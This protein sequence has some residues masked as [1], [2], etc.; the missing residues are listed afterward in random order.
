M[1]TGA[2]A[3][4]PA[5]A[6][7]AAGDKDHYKSAYRPGPVATLAATAVRA[8]VS[9]GGPGVDPLYNVTLTW[10][11]DDVHV[12][13]G[14]VVEKLNLATSQW[15]SV[16][17][18][19]EDA[20]TAR[21][22]FAAGLQKYRVRAATSALPAADGYGPAVEVTVPVGQCANGKAVPNVASSANHGLFTD[23]ETL[24]RALDT[25]AFANAR[26]FQ[27]TQ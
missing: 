20:S 10:N 19:D 27:A 4:P 7:P 15:V 25:L 26:Y 9:P 18:L 6:T 5:A 13:T 22:T 2:T 24:L 11:P 16:A 1:S 8:P 23:C 3:C 17:M 21:V 12:E 14:F